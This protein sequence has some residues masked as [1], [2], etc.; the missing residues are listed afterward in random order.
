MN[1]T[2]I[3]DFD[4]VIADSM[5][6]WAR[7]M[8]EILDENNVSYPEN[9]IEIITPLGLKRTAEY[10]ATLGIKEK[11]PE[12]ILGMIYEKM[13]YA[14]QNVIVIKP[15]VKEKLEQL[16]MNGASLNILTAS[17][18]PMLDPCLKRNGIFELFDNLWS[19]DDF[20]LPKSETP[21]YFEAAKLLGKDVSECIFFDDN[22]NNVVAAKKAGL[23]VYG[24][25][26]E[27]SKDAQHEIENACDKYIF[28]FS[29][30]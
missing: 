20:N 30:I 12:E 14:Y 9:I 24:V 28:D 27:T 7:I 17:P 8:V 21:I 6:T 5:P 4:G 13:L 16:K 11:A 1:N 25:Y 18:H 10:F 15:Y 3:F 26:D 22:I 29:Q 23:F 2:Y 19:C